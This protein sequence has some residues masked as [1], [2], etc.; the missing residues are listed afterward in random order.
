MKKFI[1]L[2]FV[3]FVL[4][5]SFLFSQ[6][7]GTSANRNTALRCLKLA[8]NCL[9][10]DDWENALKQANLGLS[11]DENISDLI[12]VKAVA[13]SKSGKTK[14]EVL[15]LVNLAFEKNDWVGY[16]KS[17]ARIILADLLCDTG[18]YEA[19][20]NVLDSDP[21]LYNAD[22][23]YIRIKNNYRI[24]TEQSINNARL[25]LNSTRRIYPS[26]SRFPKIFFMFETL[27]LNEN[28]KRYG[29]Y[30]IPEIVKT[31][32]AAY[33]AKLPDYSGEDPQMELMASFFA[34][35]ELQSRL[36]RAIDAKN[37]TVHPLLA[38]AGLKNGLYTEEHAIEEFFN[39]YDGA[40]SLDM[41]ENLVCLVKSTEAQEILIEKLADFSGDLLIDENYDLQSEIK[42]S[43]EKGRPL[44]ISYDKNN[45]GVIDLYSSCDLGA[46]V[47][48]H[49]YENK[50]EIF[51]DGYPKVS[52]VSFVDD[53]YDFN[54]IYDDFT[55]KPYA[56]KINP[57]LNEIG[58]DLYVP[59]F[60]GTISVPK[61][62]TVA[63]KA[64]NVQLPVSERD[65]AKV[66]FT[67]ENNRLVF[68]DYYDGNLKY[69][70]CDF[71]TGYPYNRYVDYDND[72]Y[73][74]TTETYDVIPE[75]GGFDLEKEQAVVQSIFTKLLE[76]SSIYLQKVSID[77][78]GNTV[79]EFCEQYLEYNGKI[80]F[81]DND[82]NG[83]WDC[84]YIRYPQKEG[85]SLVEETVYYGKN[86]LQELLISTMDGVPVKMLSG[87]N[88]VLVY[89]G[90]LENFYWIEDEGSEEQEKAVYEY[91]KKGITQGAVDIVQ[92]ED[93][94]ISVIKV[95]Q[96]IYCKVLPASENIIEE[97]NK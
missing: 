10:G 41:L 26:D 12:Y 34:E 81:W 85:D 13:E 87:N 56:L 77:R 51:Y 94:R 43:Y 32:A 70:T 3:T 60:D 76:S 18:N 71:T 63:M 27:I 37:Q 82:D 89:A 39:S 75:A 30:Q 86:G 24:G 45:D 19:S 46:P 59:V 21:L 48:V 80:D 58:V 42:V 4:A 1:A 83:I 16:S 74:E 36:I 50:S 93:A 28:E 38:V 57:F 65:G 64:S 78:N 5:G 40:I 88:E 91:I 90:K 92:T 96:N 35:K 62:E 67:I 73:Y 52:K 95:N 31:V 6:N 47:F 14:A 54:F 69:A 20:L 7:S 15:N 72:G 8:E 44:S 97:E 79:A 22:A 29:Q 17:G 61:I 11:Y 68:A 53:N 2:S 33:I 55:Y 25:R 84:Q 9:V 49:Y 66:V 23:E